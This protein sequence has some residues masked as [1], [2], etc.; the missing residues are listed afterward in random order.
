MRRE[1][2]DAVGPDPKWGTEKKNCVWGF[3]KLGRDPLNGE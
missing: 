1:G 3:A 2:L